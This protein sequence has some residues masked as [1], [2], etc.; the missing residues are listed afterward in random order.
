MTFLYTKDIQTEE[1]IR[2]R[3]PFTI[4]TNNI[5]YLGVPLT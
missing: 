1:E 2:E 5:K 4:G 3:I